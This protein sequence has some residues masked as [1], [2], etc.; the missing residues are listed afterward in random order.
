MEKQK[1]PSGDAKV[2]E[3]VVVGP[4]DTNFDLAIEEKSRS[5]QETYKKFYPDTKMVKIEATHDLLD[6]EIDDILKSFDEGLGKNMQ[7]LRVEVVF[8]RIVLIF[9]SA[10]FKKVVEKMECRCVVEYYNPDSPD[11]E[12]PLHF[13][14]SEEGVYYREGL[15]WVDVESSEPIEI[16]GSPFYEYPISR[17]LAIYWRPY[18]E[19]K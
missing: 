4:H 16:E 13:I 17:E 11:A 5:V 15:P 6:K 9:A 1:V 10:E 8:R 19:E 7:R 2:Y 18:G 3:H 12:V 14:N